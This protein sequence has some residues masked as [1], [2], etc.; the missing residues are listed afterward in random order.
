MSNSHL[1]SVEWKA[2]YCS[3]IDAARRRGARF[4]R[5]YA[6]RFALDVLSESDI[7]D[8]VSDALGDIWAG[9]ITWN[10]EA[11][12]LGRAVEDV[13]R[14]RLPR[15]IS[16]ALSHVPITMGVDVSPSMLEGQDSALADDTA[17]TGEAE[18]ADLGTVDPREEV[19]AHDLLSQVIAELRARV[20]EPAL[21]RLVEAFA[22]GDSDTDSLC[23]R[24]GLTAPE[25]DNLRRRLDRYLA[26]LPNALRPDG[27]ARTLGLPRIRK[28]SPHA[29]R[30]R[31]SPGTSAS[32]VEILGIDLDTWDIWYHK[33]GLVAAG[34][35][36]PSHGADV[37]LD[38]E[39]FGDASL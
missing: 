8:A 27:A 39:V 4:G 37:A 35:A 10:H 31:R 17:P 5:F 19:E 15:I 1:L 18:L 12:T 16:R 6:Q 23:A 2:A 22:D 34:L 7:E 25:L 30:P 28:P 36:A 32:T 26:D 13:L 24:L 20:T 9:T 14:T 33:A 3:Q 29:K 21:R 38:D 11:V